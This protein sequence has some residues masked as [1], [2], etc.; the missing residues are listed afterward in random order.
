MIVAPVAVIIVIGRVVSALPAAA[1]AGA[2]S[3]QAARLLV[4]AVVAGVLVAVQWLAASAREPVCSALGE[5]VNN[6]L[7]A[8]LMAAVMAPPGVAHLENPATVDLIAVGRDTFAQFMRPGRLAVELTA[9]IPA[10][11][12]MVAAAVVLTTL[13][14]PLGPLFL[15]AV[16]WA[17]HEGRE[18]ARDAAQTHYGSTQSARRKEYYLGLGTGA[19]AAK[20]VR[21]FGLPG[22]LLDG[23]QRNWSRSHQAASQR[24]G[25]Q[26]LAVTALVTVCAGVIG[27]LCYQGSRGA[28]SIGQA[29]VCGQ[30]T[31]LGLTALGSA[32]LS[33]VRTE[34]ARQALARHDSAVAATK[35]ATAESAH[36]SCGLV[37]PP[38]SPSVAITFEHVSFAYPGSGTS[39]LHDL[40]L[41][42]E[43]GQSL[44]IVGDNGVGKTTLLKLLCG[45]YPPAGGRV[46]VDGTDLASLD[47][48]RWQR[49]VAAVFQDSARFELPAMQNVGFGAVEHATDLAG[50]VAAA[51]LADASGLVARLDHGWDTVLST[52]YLHGTDLSGGEWQR[53]ALARALFAVRHGARVLILDE[54][55]AQLDARAE[56]RLYQ[57]FLDLTRGVTAIVVSHRFSTVR[58]ASHIVVVHDGRVTEQ[59]SHDELVAADGYYA[60]MFTLQAASYELDDPC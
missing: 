29:V 30:A 18:V 59:G 13:A 24:S 6:R 54:P 38:A 11:V 36:D 51:E 23:Y 53:L 39:V 56:A 20:E 49:H 34:L 58:L 35:P 22:F 48:P 12:L 1:A 47:L 9:L 7:A 17:E 25:R 43:A 31:L 4:L 26:F 52:Q 33:Q 55:A 5:R 10:R 27:W 37:L 21:V 8:G 60:R 16:L 2:G 44:A 42:I 45:L 28:V 14:W 40:N 41:T 46:L 57:R 15:A 19:E 32:S 3:H 50:V